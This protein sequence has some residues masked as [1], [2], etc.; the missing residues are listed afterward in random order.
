MSNS[1]TL[2][3]N[4]RKAKIRKVTVA[5]LFLFPA[6]IC[7]VL[8]KYIPTFQTMYYSMFRYNLMDPPGTFVGFRNYENAFRSEIFWLSFKNTLI[9]YG[10]GLILGF[11]VPIVQAI[12]ISELVPGKTLPKSR[13]HHIL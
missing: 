3:H 9:L 5:L 2:L 6:L 13:N 11:W 8:F 4:E 10:W 7:F 1:S 12:C